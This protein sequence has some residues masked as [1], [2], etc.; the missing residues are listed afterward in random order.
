VSVPVRL[1]EEVTLPVRLSPSAIERHRA[2]PRQFLFADV[3]RAP[4]DGASSAA[5]V[6]GNAVHAALDK[7]YGLRVEQR[8][9]ENLERALRAVWAENRRHGSFA[10][11]DE[12]VA[13]G[14]AA[15]QMLRLY[16][17]RFDLAAVPLGR[18]CWINLRVGGQEVYG[19][20][21]RIDEG[22]FGGIDVV[23]YKTGRRMLDARDLAHEAAVQ[24]YVLGVEATLQ[25]E[26]ER[27][28]LVYLAHGVDVVWEPERED[29][30]TLKE[31]LVASIAAIRAE[32]LFEPRPGSQ[33][34]FCPFLCDARGRV[35]LEQ[36]V[37]DPEEVPF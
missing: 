17:D 35:E 31:R 9:P 37:V 32:Q 13:A 33:C 23:D 6:I 3:E 30:E 16:A 25:R 34:G 2:C 18:E 8:Q 29:I 22:R 19:K 26:V 15:L 20:I 28:R 27:V 4:R 11:R 36:L 12:E 14:R 1:E 7:F 21:D 10:S 24:V 5:L